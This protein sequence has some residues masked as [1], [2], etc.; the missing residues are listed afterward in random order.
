MQASKTGADI[1]LAGATKFPL[2]DRLGTDNF[3]IRFLP[4]PGS[5][6]AFKTTLLAQMNET[7]IDKSVADEARKH[8]DLP[9]LKSGAP[10][11]AVVATTLG[12]RE[13]FRVDVT[14]TIIDDDQ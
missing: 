7:N 6:E 14:N 2:G 3:I 13:A 4:F 12:G 11:P 10:T 5:L 9:P 8:P 1:V